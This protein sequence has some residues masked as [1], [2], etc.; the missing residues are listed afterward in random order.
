[1]KNEWQKFDLTKPFVDSLCWVYGCYPETDCDADNEGKTVG[2]YT[3]ETRYA[4]GIATI[5]FDPKEGFAIDGLFGD[6]EIGYRDFVI[7]HF[8]RIQIPENP[9]V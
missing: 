9:E 4:K 7:T 6:T 3:G 5:Y 8:M 2:W 1:M